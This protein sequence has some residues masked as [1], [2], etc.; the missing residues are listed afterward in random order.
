M[1]QHWKPPCELPGHFHLIQFDLSVQICQLEKTN[2]L[3][4][5]LDHDSVKLF[6]SLKMSIVILNDLSTLNIHH[7]FKLCGNVD[8]TGSKAL[9]KPLQIILLVLEHDLVNES[10]LKQE[11]DPNTP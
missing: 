8:A 10:V 3:V 4:S 11:V 1:N 9:F 5:V 6:V 2:C 7:G